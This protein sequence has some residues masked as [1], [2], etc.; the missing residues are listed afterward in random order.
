[1]TTGLAVF[2]AGWLVGPG[3]AQQ[4]PDIS[5]GARDLLTISVWNQPSLSGKFE[6]GADG[7]VEFPLIGRVM[8][9]GLTTRQ[10][11][12]LIEKLLTDGYLRRPQVSVAIE[13]PGRGQRVFIIGEVRSPGTYPLADEMTLIEALARAGSTTAAAAAEALIVR[14]PNGGS[15]G[16]VL[17]EQGGGAD[18][19]KVNLVQLQTGDLSRNVTLRDGDTIFVPKAAAVY[20]SG[21]V[22]SPGAYVVSPGTTVLQAL[23]LAGGLSERG[24]SG[25]IKI[26]RL[27]DGRKKEI[28][29]KLTDLVEP[30]DTIVVS[31]RFF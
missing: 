13:Q 15:P 2:L 14:Q 19:I 18:V 30:G 27:V 3:G 28:K 12:D 23:T 24:S 31:P 29:V 8:V 9:A 16:P 17:P 26:I 5:I 10:V 4:P 7:T 6:V 25:R 11:E 20:V 1:M 21:H 22:R